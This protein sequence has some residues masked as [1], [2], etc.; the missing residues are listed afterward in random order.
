[1][2]LDYGTAFSLLRA[3]SPAHIVA[4]LA[5]AARPIGATDLAVYV[6]DLARVV[7]QPLPDGTGFGGD[8]VVEEPVADSPAGA[9]LRAGRLS[10]ERADGGWRVWVPIDDH[11]ERLG[12]LSLTIANEPDAAVVSILTDLGLLAALVIRSAARYTDIVRVRQHGQPASLSASLQWDLLPPVA[13][14]SDCATIAGLVEPAYDVGGDVFDHALAPRWLDLAIFDGMGHGSGSSLLSM[15]GVGAYRHARRQGAT[16]SEMHAAVDDAIAVLHERTAF[17]TGVISR[18][19]LESGR[20]ERTNA[21]HPLPLLVR[22]STVIELDCAVSLP[23]GLGDGCADA[24]ADDLQPGD[25]VLFYTDGV[26]EARS[27][28]GIEYGL[29]RLADALRRAVAAGLPPTGVV[30]AVLQAARAYQHGHLQD[31]ATAVV[32][33]WTGPLRHA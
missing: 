7:L 9:A 14:R 30:N 11:G 26:I 13:A 22:G 31:D 28:D 24:A 6:T 8:V 3:G 20:L 18:L 15:L 2:D 19:Y 17:A 33:H 29:D 25:H 4:P 16:V 27:E 21:G 23:F 10:S 12:V 1:M 32:L 5:A